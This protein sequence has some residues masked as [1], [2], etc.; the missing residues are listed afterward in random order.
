M[1]YPTSFN[2]RFSTNFLGGYEFQWKAKRETSL[3][4]GGKITWAG[5]RRYTP[6]L[7][8]SSQTVGYAV[9]DDS[10]RNGKQFRNYFRADLKLNYKI[11]ASRLTHEIG[12]DLVNVTGQENILKQSYTGGNPP[13]REEYQLGFLPIFY[14]KIDF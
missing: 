4:V 6:V 7:V 2:G 12:L 9:Y 3:G 5:G 1:T 14:Y 10:Q 11:N 13:L 8:D